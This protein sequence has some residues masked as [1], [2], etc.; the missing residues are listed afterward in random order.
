MLSGPNDTVEQNQHDPPFSDLVD[1]PPLKKRKMSEPTITTSQPS[2]SNTPA[3]PDPTRPIAA[4]PTP[5]PADINILPTSAPSSRSPSL[6]AS[7]GAPPGFEDSFTQFVNAFAGSGDDQDALADVGSTVTGNGANGTADFPMLVGERRTSPDMTSEDME[8]NMNM[9]WDSAFPETSIHP[10]DGMS[11]MDDMGGMTGL[12]VH[13]DLYDGAREDHGQTDQN[14]TSENSDGQGGGLELSEESKG[15]TEEPGS[16]EG[17]EQLSGQT[18]SNPTHVRPLDVTGCQPSEI[19]GLP[20]SSEVQSAGQI[21]SSSGTPDSIQAETAAARDSEESS[22]GRI[23]T[24]PTPASEPQ[25]SPPTPT[26]KPIATPERRTTRGKPPVNYKK[27]LDGPVVTKRVVRAKKPLYNEKGIKVYCFCRNPD[28]GKFMIQCDDCKEWYHGACVNMTRKKAEKMPEYICSA[29]QEG[30]SESGTPTKKG[31]KVT[32]SNQGP[33]EADDE[34]DEDTNESDNNDDGDDEYVQPQDPMLVD[35]KVDN[36]QTSAPRKQSR[37]KHHSSTRNAAANSPNPFPPSAKE[38]DSVR[39]V[40]REN[41]TATLRS[42]FADA[43]ALLASPPSLTLSQTI[44]LTNPKH[45]ASIIEDELFA[46]HKVRSETNPREWHVGDAYKSRYRSIQFNLKD[47]AN[48]RLPRRLLSGAMSPF[49]LVSLP[50]EELGSEAVKAVVEEVKKKSLYN[51]LKVK[52]EGPIYRKTHKGEEEIRRYDPAD[53]MAL[54]VG[55]GGST[56]G[57]GNAF[58]GGTKNAVGSSLVDAKSE[59]DKKKSSG[60][61]RSS[62]ADTAKVAKDKTSTRIGSTAPVK[63]EKTSTI[64]SDV[65]EA[66][67]AAKQRVEKEKKEKELAPP[68]PPK[69]KVESLDELLAKMNGDDKKRPAEEGPNKNGSSSGLPKKLKLDEKKQ[70]WAVDF[71]RDETPPRTDFD[72]E[73]DPTGPSGDTEYD[74]DA[75]QVDFPP[76]SPLYSPPPLPQP[77]TTTDSPPPSLD[78]EEIIWR[79]RIHMRELGIFTGSCKQVAGGLLGDKRVWEDLLPAQIEIG[80]RINVGVTVKYIMDQR[81]QGGKDVVVVEFAP[82]ES[83]SSGTQPTEPDTAS[84]AKFYGYFRS[85]DRFAVVEKTYMSVKDMYLVPLGKDEAVPR[86][87]RELSDCRVQEAPRERDMLFGVLI[88]AKGFGGRRRS[89]RSRSSGYHSHPQP[90]VAAPASTPQPQQ[91]QVPSLSSLF[92]TPVSGVTPSVL[93]VPQPGVP[94]L[95]A[96]LNDPMFQFQHQHPLAAAPAVP[97]QQ[98]DQPE[99]QQQRQQNMWNAIF[100]PNPDVATIQTL[101]AQLQQQQQQVQQQGLGIGIGGGGLNLAALLALQQQQQPQQQL[102]QGQQGGQQ[103]GYQHGY[104]GGQ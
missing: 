10:M 6:G 44:T 52:E 28:D 24:A 50:V 91:M 98:Q 49:Q 36:T 3:C 68:P 54:G 45:F 72:F 57:I 87:M 14:H 26:S 7:L 25:P 59:K 93:P 9:D 39:R 16:Q 63:K 74:P 85:R 41:L 89:G 48:K 80:G 100:G 71:G 19:F 22:S 18:W 46:Y 90:M 76:R 34:S 11:G 104:W 21:E 88:M 92:A 1:T 2:T 62:G 79:G 20:R 23:D 30:D 66:I 81:V 94:S 40:A 8:L 82:E 69:V 32:A 77:T 83:S 13:A 84:Y 51:A 67:K 17:K 43:P 78:P 42:V 70:S 38:L 65:V 96:A 56:S 33:T 29:C 4:S 53:A 31:D 60:P 35:G 101:L 37:P 103:P 86:F 15:E 12:G 47:K 97:P 58:A 99:P 102:G 55:V 64:R 27:L 73:G 5:P 95:A 61:S 75:M